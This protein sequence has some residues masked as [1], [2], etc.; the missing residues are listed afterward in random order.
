MRE[1]CLRQRNTPMPAA[2][3]G[4]PALQAAAALLQEHVFLVISGE[5]SHA[6][7]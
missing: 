2:L 4:W 6:C 1:G 5:V 7:V 3:H